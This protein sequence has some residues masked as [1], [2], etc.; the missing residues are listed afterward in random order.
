[1]YMDLNDELG[2]IRLSILN[3]LESSQGH[4]AGSDGGFEGN[5]VTSLHESGVTAIHASA[6]TSESRLRESPLVGGIPELL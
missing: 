3:G 6:V 1:M 4:L 2:S 5:P